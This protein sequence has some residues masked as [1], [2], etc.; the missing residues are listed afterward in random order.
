VTTPTA[1]TAR[2]RH[3][4][5]VEEL[6]AASVRALGDDPALTFRGRRLYRGTAPVP[7]HVPHLRPAEDDDL[8]LY[9]GVA[10]G[11]ALRHLHTDE[12]L[13]ARLAPDGDVERLVFDMLEQ[14]RAESLARLPGVLRNL[15]HRHETWSAAF[16]DSGLTGG[17]VGLLLY[18]VAQ[19][20]RSRVTA[21]PVVAA[22]EHLI[23][24]TRFRLAPV[25]G[26]DLAGLRRH[27][28][29][30]AAYARHALAIAGTVAA[31]VAASAATGGA[32]RA[33]TEHRRA[34]ALLIEQDTPDP[35]AD[36]AGSGN[37]KVSAEAGDGYRVFTRAYDR[38]LRP[39]ERMRADR[40]RELRTRLDDRVA[41]QGVNVARLAGE[42]RALL[43]EPR[44]DGW[45]EG[46]EAGHI[47]GRRLAQL[48][49]SPTERRLFRAERL[50]PVADSAVSFLVDCSGSMRRHHETVAL[51]LDVLT[52]ALDLTGVTSEVLGFSTGAWNGGRALRDWRR[53]G[54]PRHPGRVNELAHLVFKD[55]DTPWRTARRGIAALL[56]DDLYREGVD[57]EAVAWASDRLTARPESRRILV[58][59]SDGGPMDGATNLLNDARYLDHHL[60][61]VVA[62]Q[63]SR[64]VAVLGLGVGFDLSPFYARSVVLDLERTTGNE[65]FRD[66]VALLARAVRR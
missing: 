66:V 51:L 61:Q 1:A 21:E 46:Q 47:D 41:R 2:T 20:A 15:R 7:T 31:M 62:Q 18:T 29:D 8:A 25:I 33:V 30:Q 63:E 13:H 14:F 9:R 39:A 64:G 4:Q 19:A 45:D 43:T 54:R 22:T 50:Q 11:F 48:I 27:R 56:Q 5:Q 6:C 32:S 23:E 60:R 16:H 10:D 12:A 44:R 3:R 59:V 52:R 38:T 42:L 17:Q 49:T 36:T 28:H 55:A 34:F 35:T 40:L 37:K 57:G 53:A 26:A 65:M 24:E 58:V